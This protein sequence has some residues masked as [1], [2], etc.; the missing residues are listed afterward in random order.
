MVRQII[1]ASQHRHGHQLQTVVTW[2]LDELKKNP[3]ERENHL[4]TIS[5]MMGT[6]VQAQ[7]YTFSSRKA[8]YRYI[9]LKNCQKWPIGAKNGENCLTLLGPACLSITK[10]RGGAPPK[11]LGVGWGLRFQFFLEMACCGM[12]YHIQKDS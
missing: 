2:V 11:Y 7:L 10:D 12:N 1:I 5:K 4:N 6:I 9:D 8:L 3:K